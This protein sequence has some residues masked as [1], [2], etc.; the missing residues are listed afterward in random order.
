[1]SKVQKYRSIEKQIKSPRNRASL[2][3]LCL[4]ELRRHKAEIVFKNAALAVLWMA[5]ILFVLAAGPSAS[6]GLLGLV[7]RLGG[8]VSEWHWI[9]MG[10]GALFAVV[11]A[12]VGVLALGLSLVRRR[13]RA[14]LAQML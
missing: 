8:G 11:L 6:L 7:L 9:G 2:D 14:K 13:Y 12:P 5:L 3:L 1:M 10:A 4:Q